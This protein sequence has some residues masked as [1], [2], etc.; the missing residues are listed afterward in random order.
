[1]G[2][3]SGAPSPLLI[4]SNTYT[5]GNTRT[6]QRT[7]ESTMTLFPREDKTHREVAVD[8]LHSLLADCPEFDEQWVKFTLTEHETGR[9][10]L[11]IR[12]EDPRVPSTTENFKIV[13]WMLFIAIVTGV[14]AFS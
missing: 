4:F 12:V 6:M 7:F 5:E 10:T 1:M 8:T 2:A 13:L 11:N 14:I 3:P 9:A